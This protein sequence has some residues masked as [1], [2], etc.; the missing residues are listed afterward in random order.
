MKKN[1]TEKE[2]LKIL[3]WQEKKFKEAGFGRGTLLAKSAHDYYD[4]LR[5]WR[6]KSDAI[7]KDYAD[8]KKKLA[9]MTAEAKRREDQARKLLDEARRLKTSAI[10]Y[11]KVVRNGD[12]LSGHE[13]IAQKRFFEKVELLRTMKVG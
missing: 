10:R 4:E 12:L 7:A 6:K 5:G 8:A 9:A 13:R 11:K 3:A 1:M 2:A